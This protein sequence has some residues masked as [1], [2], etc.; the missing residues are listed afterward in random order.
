M[1]FC[2]VIAV[3]CVKRKKQEQI[4]AGQQGKSMDD[5]LASSR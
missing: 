3:Y 1:A 4:I 5:Y 2:T